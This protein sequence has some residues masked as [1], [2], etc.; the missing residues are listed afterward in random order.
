N[1]L[2]PDLKNTV[3]S[4]PSSGGANA[5]ITG[6]M[7]VWIVDP[8]SYNSL[9]S[10]H[11][12]ENACYRCLCSPPAFRIPRNHLGDRSDKIG[13]VRCAR[14]AHTWCIFAL[15]LAPHSNKSS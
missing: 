8:A 1:G 6:K 15:I 13:A 14:R 3:P 2:I 4:I 12:V 10:E 9:L 11:S 5:Y 7:A